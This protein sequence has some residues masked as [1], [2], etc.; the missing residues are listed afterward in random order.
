MAG[1]ETL[2]S[3]SS[4]SPRTIITADMSSRSLRD[5][6]VRHRRQPDVGIEPDLVAGMAGEHRTATRLRH[7]ADQDSG[8]PRPFSP[9]PPAVSPARHVGMAQ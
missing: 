3:T 7:V 2:G 1:R 6:S 5:K 9:C 8:Q 4:R